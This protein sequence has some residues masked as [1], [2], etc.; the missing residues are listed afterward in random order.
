MIDGTDE[1]SGAIAALSAIA[2]AW[3]AAM[4]S[5][6]PHLVEEPTRAA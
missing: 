6:P 2:D 3:A 1:R 4:P 5:E